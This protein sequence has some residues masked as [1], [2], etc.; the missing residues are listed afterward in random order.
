MAHPTVYSVT[1]EQSEKFR[2]NGIVLITLASFCIAADPILFLQAQ[3]EWIVAL[4]AIAALLGNLGFN[5]YE[6]S[7]LYVEPQTVTHE[8]QLFTSLFKTKEEDR[9]VVE[10]QYP[11]DQETPATLP[12]VKT[13]LQRILN[14]YASRRESFS[15]DPFPEIDILF[16][17]EAESLRLEVGLR[18]VTLRTI[19]VRPMTVRP[20][21]PPRSISV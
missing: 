2:N 1:K 13:Y 11:K 8:L 15:D 19:A 20:P 3:Y 21:E 10:I 12:R 9:V 5:K 14:I 6:R 18:E 16:Q 17:R 4:T 7:A